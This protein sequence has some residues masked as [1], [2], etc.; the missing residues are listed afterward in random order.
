MDAE[1]QHSRT[2]LEFVAALAG[3]GGGVVVTH[4]FS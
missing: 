4:S 1:S 3:A 2:E